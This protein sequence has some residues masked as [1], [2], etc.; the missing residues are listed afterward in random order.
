MQFAIG[1]EFLPSYVDLYPNNLIVPAGEVVELLTPQDIDAIEVHGTLKVR[2][3]LRYINLTVAEGGR[4]EIADPVTLTKKDVSL[5]TAFDPFQ[6]GHGIQCFGEW[7]VAGRNLAQTWSLIQ[8]VEKGGTTITLDYIPA[9]WQ[10]GDSLLIPDTKQLGE[11]TFNVPNPIRSESPVKIAAISGNTVTLSKP[12]DFEHH[13]IK[14]PRTGEVVARPAVANCTRS[15]VFRSENPAV[16][17]HRG[18]IAVIHTGQCDFRYASIVGMGRTTG[19]A[20]DNTP[21]DRSRIGTNQIAKYAFHAHHVAHHAG[22]DH[23]GVHIIGCHVDGLNGSKWGIVDHASPGFHAEENVITGHT[24][25]A[26]VT[27][28]GNE[29]GYLFK[30]NFCHGASGNGINGRFNML[31]LQPPDYWHRFAPGGEGAGIWHH[32]ANGRTLENYCIN[33]VVGI[34]WMYIDHPGKTLVQHIP[35]VENARNICIS[36]SF[37]GIE[38]WI[39]PPGFY[40]DDQVCANNTNGVVMGNGNPGNVIL[41][42]P[43]LVNSQF[44]RPDELLTGPFIV[45]S[46]ISA[47][48]AYTTSITVNG[49]VVSGF[50]YGLRDAQRVDFRNVDARGNGTYDIYFQLVPEAENI[51]LTGTL[52]ETKFPE[53]ETPPP[54]EVW[55]PANIG[56]PFNGDATLRV[57]GGLIEKKQ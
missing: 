42:N 55:E 34:Q 6:W 15:I 44:T 12:L 52:Y 16:V 7:V 4:L 24:G 33:N 9:D 43:T 46:G 50:R 53:D 11:Y 38:E 28:D 32:S 56:P 13:A 29:T 37:A 51:N 5:D 3:D 1:P 41:N 40:A 39:S 45:G 22:T 14:H 26:L 23:G 27:E 18:H 10:V 25:S 31:L 2:A 17:S 30:R 57:R 19:E 8:P 36:N 20:L 21:L 49:G 35:P 54:V 47:S 48:R